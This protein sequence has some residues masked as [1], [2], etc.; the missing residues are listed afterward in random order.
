[1]ADFPDDI[2]SPRSLDNLNG[3]IYDDTDL[4]TIFAEDINLP[5]DEIVAIEETLGLNPEGDF[6][7]VVER[8]DALDDL[9]PAFLAKYS[10]TSFS[11]SADTFTVITYD[12]VSFDQL[13]NYSNSTYRFTAPL[14]GIYSFAGG[15][16]FSAATSFGMVSIFVN[17]SRILDSFD[18]SGSHTVDIA[19]ILSLSAG[20]YVE[21]RAYV[22]VSGSVNG[23]GNGVLSTF[24][25]GALV[26]KN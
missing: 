22:T 21:I 9:F 6:D 3:I 11:L 8:L 19:S 15:A 16:N 14:D 13:S 7:T 18:I 10:G 1:M 5:N 20:D 17:G 25:S 2:F 23:L 12:S 26:S 4:E 24:F